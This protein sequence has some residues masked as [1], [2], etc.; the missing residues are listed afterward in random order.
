MNILSLLQSI[1]N[2]AGSVY[3]II[4]KKPANILD[5][6]PDLVSGL[7]KAIDVYASTGNLNTKD[8]IDSWFE[9]LDARTGN[10]EGSLHLLGSKV[11]RDDEEFIFDHLIEA[12]RRYAYRKAGVTV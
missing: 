11:S 8:Q 5:V 6:L 12:G 4:H 1:A 10:E 2:A 3:S 7:F 9:M